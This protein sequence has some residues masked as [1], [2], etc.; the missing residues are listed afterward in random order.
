[1]HFLIGGYLDSSAESVG[2][3]VMR[4]LSEEINFPVAGI[5]VRWIEAA[6]AYSGWPNI[7]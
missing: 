2:L 6:A 1:M 3:I 4:T 7:P 5:Q